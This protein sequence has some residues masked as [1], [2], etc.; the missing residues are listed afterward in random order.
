MPEQPIRSRRTASAKI[1]DVDYRIPP[2][3]ML[4]LHVSYLWLGGN[5]ESIA[6]ERVRG[7]SF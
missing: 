2:V 1:E 6:A 5:N 7:Q 3:P 4:S